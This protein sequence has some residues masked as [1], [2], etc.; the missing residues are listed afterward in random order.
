MVL[1]GASECRSGSSVV[2]VL[3][4]ELLQSRNWFDSAATCV[5]SK[6]RVSDF[7]AFKHVHDL[8]CLKGGSRV[9]H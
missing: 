4:L 5:R 3:L 1:G 9:C 7:K 6:V 2:I 8:L